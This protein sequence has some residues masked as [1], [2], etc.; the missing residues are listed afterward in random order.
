MNHTWRHKLRHSVQCHGCLSLEVCMVLFISIVYIEINYEYGL[1]V[2]VRF[3][4]QN[5]T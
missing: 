5:Y 4:N 3:V 1:F 2:I